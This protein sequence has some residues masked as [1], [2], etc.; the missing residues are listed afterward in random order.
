LVLVAL[1]V[2]ARELG[3]ANVW[4][5]KDGGLKPTLRILFVSGAVVRRTKVFCFFFSK[6]KCFLASLGGDGA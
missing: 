6:K 1:V 2:A 4:G 3:D 5:T